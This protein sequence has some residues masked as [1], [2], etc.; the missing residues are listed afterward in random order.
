MSKTVNM[1]LLLGNL[2]SDASSAE[3]N[4][5]TVAEFRLATE[6]SSRQAD[7]SYKRGVN[8]HTVKVWNAEKVTR[9]L[10]K[11]TKVHVHGSLRERSWEKDGETRY[12]TEV[13]ASARGLTLLGSAPDAQDQGREEPPAAAGGPGR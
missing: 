5:A 9:Y 1:V 12:V 10:R 7:G 8:W 6:H 4:G 3:V 13:V 11:G 2:G